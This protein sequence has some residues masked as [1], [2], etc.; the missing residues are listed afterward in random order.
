VEVPNALSPT[1]VALNSI[2]F[3]SS[4]SQ[5]SLGVMMTYIL[6]GHSRV[7]ARADYVGR[8]YNAGSTQPNYTGPIARVLYVWTPTA[9][10][11]VNASVSRDVGP[12]EDITT[13][14]VLVTGGYVRPEWQVTDKVTLK[15]NAEYNVWQYKSGPLTG[16]GFTHHQRLFGV[17]ASWRPTHKIL[18]Q[19]GY[20]YEKR[21]STLLF[22]D[23]QDEVF[24]VEGRIGF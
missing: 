1:G 5:S 20:N 13:A 19:A 15:A 17:S 24:F 18:L 23:Y 16:G 21:L 22:G 12:A 4:Y 11:T 7:D 14:F 2:P 3:E 9:K 10:F 8:R 6:T